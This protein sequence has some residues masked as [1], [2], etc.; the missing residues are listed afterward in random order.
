MDPTE[1]AAALA[2]A[3]CRT[4]SAPDDRVAAFD[5]AATVE[6]GAVVVSGVVSARSLC[7]RA[8]T[9]VDR[10]V[11]AAVEAD[12]VVL[13]A[14]AV[15]RVVGT[16]VISC[17]GAPDSDAERVTQAVYGQAVRGFDRRG[18]WRRVRTPDG[19][20]AWVPDDELVAPADVE[21]DAV[22]DA[23]ALRGAGPVEVLYA[24][25][26]CKRRGRADDG[27][28]GTVRV[29]FR[30]GATATLPSSAVVAPPADPDGAAVVAA[31]ATYLG[32]EYLW[33]G[34]TVDGVDCSGLVWMAYRRNGLVLPRDADQQR[35]AGRRVERDALEPGDL[36]FFPGHVA[37]SAGDSRVVHAEAA[38][39]GVV[40][41]SLDPRATAQGSHD[42]GYSQRLDE[43]FECA[44]RPL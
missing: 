30:T 21:P 34:T 13:E 10:A 20:L 39:G 36:L 4:R 29:R 8:L 26:P 28:N 31:A 35:A 23:G 16:P 17:R 14:D 5:L 27:G 19:Y 40:R 1:R 37:V 12:V 32:T 2:L 11:G 43:E 38:A 24:G 9:A 41:A 18:R 42:A 22:V 44:R 25:V 6:D 7:E 15:E 33:G 3:R